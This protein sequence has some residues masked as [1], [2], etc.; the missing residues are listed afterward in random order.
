MR[1]WAQVQAVARDQHAVVEGMLHRRE[2]SPRVRERVEM[3]KAVALGYGP[4]AIATW[5]GRSVR[6]VAY[7]LERFVTNGLAALDDAPRAGR[8]PRATPAYLA[9]LETA[10]STPPRQL[11]LEFD[12]W[13]SERLSAYL[14]EQTG[15]R[16]SPGWLRVLLAQHDWVSGRPKLS[17][18]HL[19][20]PAEVAACEAA[21]EA[22]E[23]KRGRRSGASGTA[24]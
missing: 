6:T 14:V 16:L 2:L 12:V 20:R 13:T 11:G 24:P 3:V 4:E 8:P 5:S 7:W 21:L 19:R 9:A 1:E 22:A 18:R 10:V 23:K 15:I 17:V